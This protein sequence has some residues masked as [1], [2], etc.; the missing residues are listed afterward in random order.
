MTVCK[1]PQR[2]TANFVLIQICKRQ[3][4]WYLQEI[5]QEAWNLKQLVV[6]RHHNF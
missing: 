1:W 4:A 6:N 3:E 5:M 2:S